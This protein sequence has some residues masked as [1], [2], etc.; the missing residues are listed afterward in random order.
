VDRCSKRAFADWW[1]T[2]SGPRWVKVDEQA[3]DHRRFWDV[4]DRLDE[5]S[6][7]MI[8]TPIFGGMII[9][10][11]RPVTRLSAESRPGIGYVCGPAL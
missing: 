1:A 9:A 4:M 5:G 6:L 2:T 10:I 11:M 7:R 3:L 8:E